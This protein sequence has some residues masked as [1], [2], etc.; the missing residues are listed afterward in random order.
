[1][2]FADCLNIKEDFAAVDGAAT[3]DNTYEIECGN[4]DS[5]CD[6]SSGCSEVFPTACSDDGDYCLCCQGPGYTLLCNNLVGGDLDCA[7][8]ALGDVAFATYTICGTISTDVG[9]VVSSTVD[10]CV[11]ALSCGVSSTVGT[12]T[13]TT[14]CPSQAGSDTYSCDDASDC[15]EPTECEYYSS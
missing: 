9:G 12:T 13:T 2:S 4:H 7:A 6:D 5:L 11:S 14:T 15:S 10:N 1:M 8:N 3:Y